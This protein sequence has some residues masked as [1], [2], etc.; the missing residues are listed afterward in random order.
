MA[1]ADTAYDLAAVAA[2]R[3]VAAGA[4]PS[5]QDAAVITAL[6]RAAA[7]STA[8]RVDGA[9]REPRRAFVD[10]VLAAL[11]EDAPSAADASTTQRPAG[12]SPAVLVR[13]L[14][15]IRIA[16]R[17]PQT[18]QATL[19]SSTT[20]A[21]LLTLARLI[22][23]EPAAASPPPATPAAPSP[24]AVEAL[25]CL[26]NLLLQDAA[27]RRRLHSDHG[28]IV[29]LVRELQRVPG[30]AIEA[31]A[32]LCRLLFLA[33]VDTT[34]AVAAIAAV[35]SATPASAAGSPPRGAVMELDIAETAAALPGLIAHHLAAAGRRYRRPAPA[36]L[37]STAVYDAMMVTDLLK[38]VFQL[39]VARGAQAVAS[40]SV[41]PAATSAGAW[42]PILPPL[43]DV[44]VHGNVPGGHTFEPP[45]K[46]A[47]HAVLNLS[48]EALL[49]VHEQ[50]LASPSVP[51][52]SASASASEP[53]SV[54]PLVV[55]ALLNTLEHTL[56]VSLAA[57]T[58]R[59]AGAT[60]TS[61]AASAAAAAG[62]DE[63]V[64]AVL[65][66]LLMAHITLA[67]ADPT[68]RDQMKQRLMP[69]DLD[70]SASL[71]DGTTVTHRLIAL[72][73]V[74]GAD[75]ARHA[76]GELLYVLSGCDARALSAYVGY[77]NAA[78]Y[79][80]QQGITLPAPG[81]GSSTRTCPPADPIT[82][83]DPAAEEQ[84]RQRIR[85]EWAALTDEQKEQEAERLFVLFERLN[86]TGIIKVA[87]GTPTPSS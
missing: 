19:L 23:P 3:R 38:I 40:A 81:S 64:D 51:A 72:L 59:H 49:A 47:I 50:D 29:P 27:S 60:H 32:M 4:A 30:D 78:G 80:F 17:A 31:Q 24:V 45:L 43:V 68:A 10:A 58:G 87:Q 73:T 54:R 75:H 36:S 44:L 12:W 14:G 2:S 16:L 6:E 41:A 74:V 35:L 55:D 11:A 61:T 48:P 8:G 69:A 22:P 52:R 83:I 65:G 84:E 25:K 15:F 18:C 77:G 82:G 37:N 13:A 53:E 7:A 42:Q 66:P 5:A 20:L 1:S 56:C 46:H 33:T 76:A 26:C 85:D 34:D 79:L 9:D 21:T 70:R 71:K 86:R 39:T 63:P 62:L 57:W 28:G 67:Q